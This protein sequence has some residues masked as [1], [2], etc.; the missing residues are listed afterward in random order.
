MRA[1]DS[2]YLGW[3]YGKVADPDDLDP[4]QSYWLLIEFLARKEFVP[5]CADDE[6]RR[7]AV[8]E[9]RWLAREQGILSHWRE[10]TWLEVLLELAGHA[11]FLAA[12]TDAEQSMASW[13]WEF[14]GNAGFG[15]LDDESWD[16]AYA[17]GRFSSVLYGDASFFWS[18]QNSSESL[19][20]KLGDYILDRTDLI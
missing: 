9:L 18:T 11:D 5:G 7:D 10:P 19:W 4:G 20:S 2:P 17:E 14:L 6:N 13:F 12:G 3:L 16:E 15:G 8:S 1:G